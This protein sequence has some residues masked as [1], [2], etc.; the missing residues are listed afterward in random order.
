M[1]NEFVFG[2]TL[3]AS[4]TSSPILRKVDRTKVGY[5]YTG[6]YKNGVAQIPSFG[7]I[8]WTN[9]KPLGV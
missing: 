9:R 7:G 8:G 2:Y 1:T 4:R 3:S 6:L 5:D